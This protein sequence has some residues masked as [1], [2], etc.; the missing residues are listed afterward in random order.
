M[1]VVFLLGSDAGA[2]MFTFSWWVGWKP[3][4]VGLQLLA[5]GQSL[6]Q[7]KR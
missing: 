5:E 3:R 2:A 6:G 4:P 7:G 1:T